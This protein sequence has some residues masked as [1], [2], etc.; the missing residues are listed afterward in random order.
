PA[1]VLP[2]RARL[3]AEA[4][5]MGRQAHRQRV[6]VDDLLA[7]EI[8]QRH[9]GR[10]D[11]A[12]AA[13]DREQVFRELRQLTGAVKRGIPDEIRDVDFLVAVLTRVQVEHELRERAMKTRDLAA[14]HDESASRKLRRRIEVDE[15]AEPLP[16]LDVIARLEVE[17]RRLSPTANLDVRAIVRAVGDTV[18]RQVRKTREQRFELDADRLE[19]A[20]GALERRAELADLGLQRLDV[21]ARGL[22]APD[23]LRALVAPLPQRLHLDLQAFALRLERFVTFSIEHEAAAGEPSLDAVE[24]RTKKLGI[25]H[26]RILRRQEPSLHALAPAFEQPIRQEQRGEHP[27][28]VRRDVAQVEEARRRQRLQRV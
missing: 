9:L 8:R 1:R 3:G 28:R 7:H 16:D 14:Q 6:R 22:R 12:I 20:L 5:R 4:R 11:Q 17:T 27:D 15:A 2:V 18:V 23:L 13:V 25:Q 19:L 24:V 10:R 21:A 26:A